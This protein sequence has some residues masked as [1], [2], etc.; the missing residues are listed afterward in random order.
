MILLG[1]KFAYKFYIYAN[2][3]LDIIDDLHT[4]QIINAIV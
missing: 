4:M 1:T 3:V 2:L